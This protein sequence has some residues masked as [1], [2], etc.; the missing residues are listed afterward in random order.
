MQA[1]NLKWYE[2]VSLKDAKK[3][4]R[5]NLTNAAR[6][7]IAIG[8]YLKHIRD[9]E[10]Y[11][12]DGHE[13]VW[14][15]A[16]AEYG[17]SK[18]TASRYMAMNDRFSEGGNTPN[19]QEQYKQFNKSQLQ[20]MLSLNDEQLAQV[21]PSDRVE[22]IR[23]MRKPKE[24]PYIE[25][26]GQISFALNEF[27]GINP[28]EIEE[29]NAQREARQA[30][31][32]AAEPYTV[33][34]AQLV[35]EEKPEAEAQAVA[36]SQPEAPEAENGWCFHR[37]KF[38]CTLSEEAKRTPGDGTDCVEKCCWD[39]LNHGNCRLECYASSK[40]PEGEE[41]EAVARSQQEEGGEIGSGSQETAA[42]SAAGQ[43]SAY[44]TPKRVY[45]P[46]SLIATEGCEG[47]HDC[48]LCAMDCQ[49][50]GKERYCR[51]AP[52]GNPFPCEIVKDGFQD[53]GEECQF[54]N[55][56]LAD[57]MAGS[58]EAAPCCQNCTNPC[59][60]ICSRAMKKLDQSREQAE[61]EP[62]EENPD[63]PEEPEPSDIDLLRKMLEKEQGYLKE[64]AAV[65]KVE[66]D[67]HIAF[68]IRKKKLLVGALAGMLCD[69]DQPE[70]LEAPELPH[71]KNNDQRKAWLND[72]RNWPVWF[73]VP[74]A[75]EAYYRYDLPDGS[76]LVIC[77]Y[78]YWAYWK[79]EFKYGDGVLDCIG[80]REYLLKPG[81]HYLEDCKTNQTA[82]VEKL[83]EIQKGGGR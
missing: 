14:E 2:S 27:P 74:E 24:I 40:R 30:E 50:R 28:E 68:M 11:R 73:E 7:F 67:K 17:I 20:E 26:P 46:D 22:D 25:L 12:E 60:S 45:P 33:T 71:L 56:D 77:E 66:P 18:S 52:C 29:A 70:I 53:R 80:T 43:L 35:G 37:P 61:A 81:Y 65:Q 58:G 3:F 59:E 78:H 8:Y 39:C 75:A 41:L 16:Q 83:K 47:G 82:M 15:F 9:Q 10:L 57:H 13:S 54:L 72:Y 4:I 51:E 36:I 69:L 49:I 42:E 79:E 48:F 31:E 76:S 19:I 5:A 23:A 62:P 21:T 1:K 34:V 32:A 63:Q 6:S 44:G 55:H 38:Q 64:M